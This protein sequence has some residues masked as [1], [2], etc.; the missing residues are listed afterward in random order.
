MLLPDNGGQGLLSR[1]HRLSNQ[2]P[3]SRHWLLELLVSGSHTDAPQTLRVTAVAVGY[4]PH[5]NS[6]TI[7]EESVLSSQPT[8][9]TQ[10][11]APLE[12]LFLSGRFSGVGCAVSAIEG[13]NH[14]PYQ[15]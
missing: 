10:A 7:I 1:H 13:E 6:K 4:S 8:R 11:G 3:S 5:L 9:R 12:A 15:L 2:M 14:Q